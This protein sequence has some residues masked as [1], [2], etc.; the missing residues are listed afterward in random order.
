MRNVILSINVMLL[1]N[2]LKQPLRVLLELL[3][4]KY[5]VIS[6]NTTD[7]LRA[8]CIQFNTHQVICAL[9]ATIKACYTTFCY[10]SVSKATV[11]SWPA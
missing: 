8:K 2:V 1:L 3:K 9:I 4:Y 5:I 11:L 6:Q 10:Y 7:V